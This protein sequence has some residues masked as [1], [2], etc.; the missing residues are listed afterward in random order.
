MGVGI[1]LCVVV[2]RNPPSPVIASHC[3]LAVFFLNDE[4]GQI[5]LSR[6]FIAE[7]QS[8]VEESESDENLSVVLLLIES[9]GHFV[10]VIPYLG[11]LTPH[12]LPRF[13]ERGLLCLCNGETRHQVGLAV[14]G[15]CLGVLCVVECL[16]FASFFFLEFEAKSTC[17]DDLFSFETQL[18]GRTSLCIECKM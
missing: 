6:E 17:L 13:V 3:K 8:V 14:D 16:L 11:F 4:V 12:G 10:V 2:A 7:S 15:V 1:L 18:V 9:N 5:L